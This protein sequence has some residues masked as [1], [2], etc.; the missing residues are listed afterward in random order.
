MN[1][2][3]VFF[4][5]VAFFIGGSIS[6]WLSRVRLCRYGHSNRTGHLLGLSITATGILEQPRGTT[7]IVSGLNYITRIFALLGEILVRIRVDKR[8]PP[9]GTLATDRLA[10]I[11]ALHTR[12]INA[13]AHAPTPLKLKSGGVAGSAG[14]LLG[15]PGG[16]ATDYA[17]LGSRHATFVEVR[18]FFHDPNASRANAG[19]AFLV[20]QANLYVTQVSSVSILFCY[21]LLLG[22]AF[23]LGIVRSEKR[24]E[25]SIF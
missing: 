4:C 20:M 18:N 16:Y 12:I 25:L 21:F 23:R 11:R 5:F 13:L 9:H 19:N 6:K 15:A 1:Q 2:I 17:G 22:H 3:V 10:E 14:G 7:A 24:G 8:A